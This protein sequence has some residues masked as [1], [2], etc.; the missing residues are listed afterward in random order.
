MYSA[1]FF[2]CILCACIGSFA[3]NTGQ[4]QSSKNSKGAIVDDTMFQMALE[5]G[6]YY[7][8]WKTGEFA[9]HAE[10]IPPEIYTGTNKSPV[11]K[12][13]GTA[14]NEEIVLPFTITPDIRNF[15]FL[16]GVQF[17]PK[18]SL[19]NP[20]G[21]I[22]AD[23]KN[24]ILKTSHML[25]G[26]IDNPEKGEWKVVI[27]GS[28]KY[29][30]TVNVDIPKKI[31]SII[32]PPPD[33]DPDEITDYYIEKFYALEREDGLDLIRS[34]PVDKRVDV[35]HRLLNDEDTLLS[36]ISAGILFRNGFEEEAVRVIAAIILTGKDKSH[37]NNRLGYDWV[38]SDDESLAVR[39]VVRILEYI[40][41][42]FKD[43]QPDEKKRATEFFQQVGLTGEYSNEKA[44]LL[45]NNYKSR[46]QI[47][48]S[49][50]KGK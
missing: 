49:N 19:I 13:Y 29:S 32:E 1:L 9:T 33:L 3:D 26:Y 23:E 47:I 14:N 42:H 25:M 7:F 21:N 44:D 46:L 24:S 8:F 10:K 39:I 4:S 37:L 22:T 41:H 43:L 5:S 2:I 16:M 27:N 45:I 11:L 48:E 50:N 6:G 40:K 20:S 28:G 17:N 34:L 15:T 35:A 30:V 18:I 36:Y 12:D 31:D 38:H